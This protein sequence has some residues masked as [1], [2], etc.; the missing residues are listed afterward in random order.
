MVVG[1]Q[2]APVDPGGNSTSQTAL[3]QD[4]MDLL[5]SSDSDEDGVLTVHLPDIGS[6]AQC[7][8]LLVQNV[9]SVGIVDTAADIT[10]MGGKLL[11][12]VASVAKLKKKNFSSLL[13]SHHA[14]M[15][16]SRFPWTVVWNLMWNSAIGK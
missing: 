1:E 13:G 14:R 8:P 15:I 3:P 6:K 10:I 2:D 11:Q 7:V 12:K 16:R 5:Y 9:P 4:P